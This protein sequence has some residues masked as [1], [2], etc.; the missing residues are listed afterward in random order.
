MPEQRKRYRIWGRVQGVFYRAST[1]QVGKKLG[2][3]GWVRNRQDGSVECEAQ[4]SAAQLDEFEAWLAQGPA[5]AKVTR[6]D[7]EGLDL[8]NRSRS[9]LEH[10]FLVRYE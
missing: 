6:V 8:Q 7:S 1:Q 4:G 10:T 9:G 2:L 5:E 3:I